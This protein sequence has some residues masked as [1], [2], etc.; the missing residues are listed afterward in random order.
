MILVYKCPDCGKEMDDKEYK[1]R[2]GARGRHT[3]KGWVENVHQPIRCKECNR[4]R[5]ARKAIDYDAHNA[6]REY[7]DRNK[8]V[9]YYAWMGTSEFHTSKREYTE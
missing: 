2:E 4:K 5:E 8:P 3:F 7:L 6:D 9:N 1:I